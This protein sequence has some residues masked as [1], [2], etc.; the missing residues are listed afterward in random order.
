MVVFK[1]V[2]IYPSEEIQQVDN[3]DNKKPLGPSNAISDKYLNYS[4]LLPNSNNLKNGVEPA[5]LEG[6]KKKKTANHPHFVYKRLTP[7]PLYPH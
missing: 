3:F 6:L 2:I 4:F 5:I 1:I 7:P